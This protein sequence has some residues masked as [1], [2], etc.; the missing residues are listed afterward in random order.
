M[1]HAQCPISNL[2]V[3]PT[4]FQFGEDAIACFCT[5]SVYCQLHSLN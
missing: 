5:S 1:P 3:L 4:F 2:D